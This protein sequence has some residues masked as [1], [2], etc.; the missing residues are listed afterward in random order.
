MISIGLKEEKKI[1][2]INELVGP[3]F[4]D[5]ISI[6]YN[7]R[8][9][10]RYWNLALRRVFIQIKWNASIVSTFFFIIIFSFKNSLEYLILITIENCT[11]DGVLSNKNESKITI[12]QNCLSFR[13]VRLYFLLWHEGNFNSSNHILCLLQLTGVDSNN[14]F[15]HFWLIQNPN[16]V[17]V[18][19]FFFSSLF[20]Q[21][22][23]VKEMF[24]T[25]II[26]VS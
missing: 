1:A 7:F 14:F 23:V 5:A 4:G 18:T 2:W 9:V 11:V 22:N 25:H 6:R 12:N 17:T 13:S 15:F 20:K 24:F 19:G 16:N 26:I 3:I 8:V 21:K 10:V